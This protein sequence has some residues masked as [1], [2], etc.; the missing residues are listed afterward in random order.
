MDSVSFF[1]LNNLPWFWLAVAVLCIVLEGMTMALTT[2]WFGCS[3]FVLIFV[4]FLPVPFKWQLLLFV[5]LSLVLIVFTR[6]IAVKKLKVK[7]VPTN[8]DAL[9]GKT[10]LVTEKITAL[11]KGAVKVNGVT[12]SARSADGTEIARSAEC[13][14][15]KIEGATAVVTKR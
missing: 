4:S 15:T 11:Q 13:V 12:W 9:V 5:V 10:V 8:S 1:L 2:V 7:N 3:A 14:I 6:P